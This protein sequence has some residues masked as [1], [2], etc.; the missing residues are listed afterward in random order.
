MHCFMMT[1]RRTHHVRVPTSGGMDS[2]FSHSEVVTAAL[3]VV[4]PGDTPSD[5]ESAVAYLNTHAGNSR[6]AAFE[7]L[8]VEDHPVHAILRTPLTRL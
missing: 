6:D 4:T 5:R 2:E 8:M 1:Y 7:L 3:S